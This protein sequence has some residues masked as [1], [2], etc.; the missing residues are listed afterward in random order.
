[1]RSVQDPDCVLTNPDQPGADRSG[2][3]RGSKD[4]LTARQDVV[5][6]ESGKPSSQSGVREA[7]HTHGSNQSVGDETNQML[8]ASAPQRLRKEPLDTVMAV[9]LGNCD[10]AAG[11]QPA[12]AHGGP[13]IY[14]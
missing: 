9:G 7:P 12:L 2:L 1:M 5:R 8:S 11:H 10:G 3:V 4:V 13:G 6:T 14:R